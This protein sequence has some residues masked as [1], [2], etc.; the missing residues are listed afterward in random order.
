MGQWLSK[1]EAEK[2]RIQIVA[3]QV[4]G[5]MQQQAANGDLVG[6]MQTFSTIE[7]N[8]A[9]TRSYPSAVLLAQQVIPR[10]EADLA[11]RAQNVKADAAELQKT[12]A[13]TAEPAKTQLIAAAK[14]EQDRDAA[15]IADAIRTGAKWVPL[16]PR[17][18]SSIDTLQKTCTAEAS[19]LSSIP[20]ATMNLSIQKVDAARNAMAINDFKT[21]DALLKDASQLW[22][23]NEAAHYWSDRLKGAWPP[24]SPHPL[25]P[26]LQGVPLGR[27]RRRWPAGGG[28][29]RR[30]A[31]R[32]GAGQALLHDSYRRP[33]HRR[34]SSCR[35]RPYRFFRPEEP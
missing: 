13:F 12:I 7:Q 27:P 26:A 34:R 19:R 21:A 20:I 32:P 3:M 4:F 28:C 14:A 25:P 11:V 6:A 18:Q 1:E 31:P 17:C 16:I 9:A 22:A 23:Q 24:R 15:T 2:R 10:L 8:Y 30:A 33:H 35:R 5:T 29:H